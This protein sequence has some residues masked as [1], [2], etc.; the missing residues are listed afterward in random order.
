MKTPEAVSSSRTKEQLESQLGDTQV[1]PLIAGNHASGK[2]RLHK[3]RQ[4]SPAPVSRL[5]PE[6]LAQIFTVLIRDDWEWDDYES[7]EEG[8][9]FRPSWIGITY[10]CRSWR[11][12]S[13][14]TPSL[15]SRLDNF[16][17]KWVDVQLER[18]KEAVLYLRIPAE[19][20]EKEKKRLFNA[21]ALPHRLRSLTNAVQRP[22]F[23]SEG[24]PD[25]LDL[26]GS[27][28][29]LR[30]V[31]LKGWIVP[32]TSSLFSGLTS[33]KLYAGFTEDTFGDFSSFLDALERMPLL[34]ELKLDWIVGNM[35]GLDNVPKG[36][37]IIRLGKLKKL[38]LQIPIQEC[39]AIVSH[40]A[41]PISTWVNIQTAPLNNENMWFGSEELGDN[42]IPSLTSSLYSAWTHDIPSSSSS[43]A[44]AP[45]T[46][47][48]P[49]LSIRC[50]S[51]LMR[52]SGENLNTAVVDTWFEELDFTRL[53][54]GAT[55]TDRRRDIPPFNLSFGLRSWR[56]S[57]LALGA[58]GHH[59]IN[60]LPLTQLGA[61][62]LDGE[63]TAETFRI[64]AGLTSLY[65]I[66]LQ[67]H[68]LVSFL[69]YVAQRRAA[70]EQTHG[71]P[72]AEERNT[73]AGD[74][75]PPF[76]QLTRLSIDGVDFSTSRDAEPSERI[77]KAEL[78]DLLDF[79]RYRHDVVHL[80]IKWLRV[81]HAA[82]LSKT[83][84]ENLRT[85]VTDVVLDRDQWHVHLTS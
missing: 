10:V 75:A 58:L 32:W 45:A 54:E 48:P 44:G 80:P 8:R 85:F 36:S 37:R 33:L 41:Y 63:L 56:G 6:L 21:L 77:V 73:P 47:I 16:S 12:I 71:Q 64:L 65:S 79:L 29:Q 39:T 4:I 51:I 34:A 20:S 68:A 22:V 31:N 40:L 78:D 3:V 55:E 27:T 81:F 72:P 59:I 61:V 2:L 82:N 17:S 19:L 62:A 9:S 35:Q 43:R 26:I 42:L 74:E 14:N 13:L 38:S 53:V 5:P 24:R 70:L 23:V 66:H 25:F 69:G 46:T 15:W 28:P 18:S 52:G 83:D 60:S 30:Q 76:P 57:N 7:N 84:L 11:A 50:M 67:L 1:D 49:E